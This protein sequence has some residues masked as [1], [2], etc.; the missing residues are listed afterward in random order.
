MAI[1]GLDPEGDGIEVDAGLAN[2]FDHV[3]LENDA[4]AATVQIVR[5]ALEDI[6]VPA[7]PPQQVSGK[8]ATQTRP[9]CPSWP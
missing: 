9:P 1:A 7:D 5:G 8:E 4:A 2:D 3:G 6:D